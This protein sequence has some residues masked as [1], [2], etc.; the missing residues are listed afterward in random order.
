MQSRERVIGINTMG[1]VNDEI[2][3]QY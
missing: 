1:I 3:L 2:N